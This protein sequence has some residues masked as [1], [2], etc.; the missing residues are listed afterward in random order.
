MAKD[1]I[2]LFLGLVALPLWF[3]NIALLFRNSNGKG[4]L[5][6]GWT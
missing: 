1:I 5:S 6:L 3:S 4:S 2:K